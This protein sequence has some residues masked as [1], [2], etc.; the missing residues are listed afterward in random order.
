MTPISESV[1]GEFDSFLLSVLGTR[2]DYEIFQLAGDASSR[3][4]FR[5]ASGN[6]SFV[7]M[8]WEPFSDDCNYPFL[9]VRDH[10]AKHGVLVP[11]VIAKSPLQGLVLL[12]DLGD[13]TLERKFWEN[14]SQQVSLPFYRLAIDELIKMHYPCTFDRTNCTAF[15]MEFD[16]EKLLWELNYGRE[17]LLTRLCGI[18]A[19]ETEKRALDEIFLKICQRLHAEPKFIAHRDYH[20]RNI[21]L[22]L[23]K[24]RIIDFQDARLGAVQYDLVSLLRDS[25]VRMDDAIASELIAYY[26]ESRKEVTS[27][28]KSV[29]TIEDD[30]LEKFMLVY[31]VQTIQRCF[32]ACGSFASF[33]NLRSDIRYLKYLVPTL[34]TVKRSLERFPEYAP[35]LKILEDNGVFTRKFNID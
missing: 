35:F 14:Q 4:Y 19:T 24:A 18:T 5:I 11:E 30:S 31:E 20:S 26:L 16:V 34:Q 6:E 2:S 3:R 7:L 1:R 32:K 10:F 27:G 29:A 23:G 25:Y 21:M 9:S 22:K 13:L 15:K 33:Y 12:E 28:T 17:H 8:V